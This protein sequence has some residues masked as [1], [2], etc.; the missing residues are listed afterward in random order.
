MFKPPVGYVEDTKEMHE[1]ISGTFH[2]SLGMGLRCAVCDELESH[3]EW[4][5]VGKGERCVG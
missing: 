3:K 5:V 1:M 2:N 4:C